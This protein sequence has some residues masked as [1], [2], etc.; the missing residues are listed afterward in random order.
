LLDIGC[1]EGTFT[2][3][4]LERMGS[5]GIDGPWRVIAIDPD[6]A[7]LHAYRAR[8]HRDFEVNLRTMRLGVEELPTAIASDLA[9]CSHSLYATL[10]NPEL[11][12]SEKRKQIRKILDCITPGGVGF[13]SLAGQL[14]K[15][16]SV[17]KEILSMLGLADKSSYGEHLLEHFGMIDANPCA[18]QQ[19]S[20]M[21][22]TEI[23]NDASTM[24]N[25]CSYFCRVETHR[26]SQLGIEVIRDVIISHAQMFRDAPAGL[27]NEM[28]KFPAACG[29]PNDRTLFLPHTE[30]YFMVYGDALRGA[31]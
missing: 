24:L 17:K 13:F 21:D 30:L 4:L 2:A 26:L 14:S 28:T 10:E 5:L 7:N 31:S 12:S 9:I 15:A 29:A 18:T 20:Y 22:V 6:E 27:Q 1:G 23:V 8:L 19:Q 3:G 11:E 25:W 16:Y